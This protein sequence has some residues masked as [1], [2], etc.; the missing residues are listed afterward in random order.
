MSLVD[1]SA[2]LGVSAERVR[3][4]VVAGD[5]PGVRFGNAWAVPRDA[6]V[7]RRHQA[8]RR[9]RPLQA[10]RAWR[11]II[12]GHVDLASAGRY[13]ERAAVQRYQLS[14]GDLAHLAADPH[15]RRSGVAA[16]IELGQLLPLEDAADEFYLPAS[17]ATRLLGD[18]AAVEDPLG[19]V[20]LRVVD[21]AAW[22][23]ADEP[24][25]P[26]ASPA[27]AAA[28]ALDLMESGDPRHW[29]AAEALVA[30]LDG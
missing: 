20:I 28:V 1:A 4:L 14:A 17:A 24:T 10:A 16:A 3:Q 29:V 5:L 27:P 2:M 30:A 7:A 18:I 22:P 19:R 13:R 9:G 11:E 25:A 6:V 21:D 12:A 8:N 15:V 23:F 26:S